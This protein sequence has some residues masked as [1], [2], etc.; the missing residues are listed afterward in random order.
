[1]PTRLFAAQFENLDPIREFAG[2]VARQAGMEAK[3]IY[4]LQLAVDEACSNIIEHAYEGIPDGQIEVNLL[5]SRAAFKVI[6]H[7][8]GKRFDPDSIA[9]PDVEAALE[10]RAIGGLGLFFMRKLMDEVHFEW[11]PGRGNTLIMVKWRRRAPQP[12]RPSKPGYPDIFNLGEQILA[13]PTLGAQRDLILETAGRL[14]PGELILWLNPAYFHL[15]DWV[16]RV[17]LPGPPEVLMELAYA[18][19][20]TLRRQVEGVVSVAIPLRHEETGLGVLFFRRGNGERFSRRESNFMQGLAR[21]ASI[22]LLAW[23][24]LNVE[25]WRI[26]QLGLVRT[27]SAQIAN[28]ADIDELAHRVTRLIQK[29]F[30]YYYVGIF[31]L[32][33]GQQVLTF[34]SSSGG[35]TRRKG[36]IKVVAFDVAMGQG[37]VGEAAQNGQEILANDVRQEPRYRELDV[38]PETRSEAVIPLKIDERVVGVLDV[39]SDALDAFHPYDLLV[40]RAL[41]G[42]V[43]VAVEGANLYGSLRRQANQLRVVGEVSKQIT[44]ILNLR[45]LMQEVAELITSRFGF[46]YVHLFTVHHNRR[47]IH[48]EAGSGARS[49]ALEGYMIDLDEPEGVLPWVARTGL[50][51]LANNVEAEPHYRPSPLPPANTRSEL[52]VPLTFNGQVIGLLDVQSDQLNAF[53]EQDRLIFETLG[54]SI[55]A[56]IRNADLYRSEQWRRQV[57]DSLREVAVLLSANASLDQVLDAILTEL[58]RNLPSDVSA[59]WL[60]DEENLYCAAVHGARAA[61]L[62]RARDQFAEANTMLAAALLSRQPF[63]RRRTDLKGPSALAAGFDSDHSAIAVP[64]RIGDQSVGILTLAHHTPGRY[65]HEARAMTTTFASYAAVAIENARLF[66]SAQE[67]AYASAALLQVA[68][69]VVSLSDLEDI[70]STIVRIMP[71]LVGVERTAIYLWDAQTA[72]LRPSQSYGLPESAWSSVWRPLLWNEFP[73]LTAACE[74]GQMALCAEA[75]RGP[76]SW[77]QIQPSLPSEVDELIHSEERLLIALPLMVKGELFGVLLVEEAMGG[78]R[79][80]ARRL[81]I[82]H[83]IAQQVALS[84]Q[85]DLFQHEMVAR[86]RL[87]T[88]VQLAR[89]IQQTF[90]PEKLPTPPNWDLAARWRTARQVGGDFYD[91]FELPDGKLGLFIADVADKG[92]PAAMFMALTRTLMRAAVLIT[93]SPAGALRQ[94]NELLYPDAQQ[95]MFVTAVYGVLDPATGRFTYANAGHNPPLLVRLAEPEQ[96][97]RLTRTGVALGVDL[98]L[99]RSE[100]SLELAHGDVLLFYTDGITEAFSGSEEIFGE[101]RLQALLTAQPPAASAAE[102]LSAVDEAVVHFIGAAPVADDITL[103][104]IKRAA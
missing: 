48:Y 101:E 21:V 4:N 56:A 46:P 97:E 103:I 88:E 10:D 82:L 14:V 87:E 80:R 19:G 67:Q 29:T 100:R 63:I 16:E 45:E 18:Q 84:I 17:F 24:R 68:Q 70:L 86:E 3:D 42:S 85:N 7:D 104:V 54:D 98:G 43:A 55:A 81:E 32:E 74:T 78:R 50:T 58:E 49:E 73:L 26:G 65:G 27:V 60:L 20:R 8:Q 94:V 12:A 79:F 36:R 51:L 66:D 91:V 99:A 39:Q 6:L 77:L 44:S 28:E 89:Q 25:R 37:L 76:E 93:D 31:T 35:A 95:G 90:I 53:N 92:V 22:A 83:G 102:I 75:H 13:A 47:Q 5:V 72:Q 11:H 9:E 64:L 61:D 62:E 40:L 23:H 57:A 30:K 41:A 38:L 34:R 15:P 1:M 71:I 33:A 59:V 96:I 52:T 69:A 2:E